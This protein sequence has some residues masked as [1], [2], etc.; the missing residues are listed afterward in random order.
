MKSLGLWSEHDFKIKISNNKELKNLIGHIYTTIH[1]TNDEITA[2]EFEI[3]ILPLEKHFF[4]GVL[5]HELFHMF[6]KLNHIQLDKHIEEGFAELCNYLYLE[7]SKSFFNSKY[8]NLY[9]DSIKDRIKHNE[10]KI[11]GNGFRHIYV[12]YKTI[13]L[14]KLKKMIHDKF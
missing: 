12:L 5:A 7:K 14:H 9:I 8:K 3:K 10:D 11:Y 4:C 2:M 13:R 1:Y 6:I